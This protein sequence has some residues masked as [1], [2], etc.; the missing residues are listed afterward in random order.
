MLPDKLQHQQ[1][2]E[3]CIQQGPDDRVKFPV[4]VVRPFSEI[5]NHRAEVSLESSDPYYTHVIH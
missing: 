1:L 4:V 5:D 2:V 3:I